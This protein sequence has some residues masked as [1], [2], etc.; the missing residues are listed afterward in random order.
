[1]RKFLFFVGLLCVIALNAQEPKKMV[2]VECAAFDDIPVPDGYELKVRQLPWLLDLI[3]K[4][5][6]Y[7]LVTCCDAYDKT[8]VKTAYMLA[9]LKSFRGRVMKRLGYKTQTK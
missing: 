3:Q 6:G 2:P 4:P 5:G 1:M 9:A 8:K 7:L